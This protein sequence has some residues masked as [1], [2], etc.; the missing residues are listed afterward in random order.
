[1]MTG[2]GE[3]EEAEDVAGVEGMTGSQA[4]ENYPYQ[5]IGPAFEILFCSSNI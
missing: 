5:K 1:M 3:V 4:A 2:M